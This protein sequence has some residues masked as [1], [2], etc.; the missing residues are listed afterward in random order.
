VAYVVPAGGAETDPSALRAGLTQVLPDYMVPAAFVSLDA[1]PSTPSGKVDRRAL[2]APDAAFE[3]R[4]EYVA[5]RSEVEVTLAR[6]WAEVLGAERVGVHDNFFEL[7]G[8][9]IGSMLITS[10]ARATFGIDLTPRD[11]LSAR[12]VA[13]L[14][15]LVEEKILYEL[16]SVAFGDGNPNDL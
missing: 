12:T 16:E 11:V 13:N 5:P 4:A 14:A 2:P 9:S 7:G 3:A 6:V 10:R 15:D 8:D 1:L